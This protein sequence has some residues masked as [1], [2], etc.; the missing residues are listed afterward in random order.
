MLE[1]KVPMSQELYYDEATNEFLD[2]EFYVIQ[3]E[4]SLSSLSKWEEFFEKAFL[5]KGEKTPEEFLWYIKVMTLTP[6]VPPEVFNKLT[7]QNYK[8]VNEYIHKKMT[9]LYFNNENQKPSNEVVT[10][11]V[12]YW[13]M[14]SLNIPMECQYWHL[15]KL[16][17]LIQVINRKQNPPKKMNPRDIARRNRELNA[18][19]RAELGTTG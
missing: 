2:P 5:G 15:N 11:E 8:D 6:D 19:R 13:M 9:A 14:I 16:L 7:E 17:A 4:H 18:R 10:N 3:L 1:L 12:L